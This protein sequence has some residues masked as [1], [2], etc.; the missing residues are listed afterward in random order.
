MQ[1]YADIPILTAAPDQT[2]QMAFRIIC[3]EYVDVTTL[4]SGDWLAD[5]SDVVATIRRGQL[6]ILVGG[7]GFYFKAAAE[8]IVPMP[9]I[10]P[11]IKAEAESALL[12]TYGS[13]ALHSHLLELILISG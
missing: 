10:S 6:P 12:N 11:D 4:F 5:A 3:L 9:D 8:G 13:H 1:V 7:T 2:D